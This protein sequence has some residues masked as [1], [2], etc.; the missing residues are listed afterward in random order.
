MKRFTSV[1][2][3][4]VVISLAPLGAPAQET[5]SAQVALPKDV[6]PDSGN[7]LPD[8]SAVKRLPNGQ[9]PLLPIP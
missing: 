6:Y 7:R 3:I 8:V 2:Y 9:K 4:L 5:N 1:F